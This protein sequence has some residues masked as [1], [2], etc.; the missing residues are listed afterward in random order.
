MIQLFLV[1]PDLENPVISNLPSDI[2]KTTDPGLAT[3]VVTWTPPDV[4]DNTAVADTTSD[5]APGGMFRIGLTT[6]TYTATDVYNN[7]E[8]ASFTVTIVGADQ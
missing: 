7:V 2:T 3:A 1:S 8:M 6:V 4:T 5:H